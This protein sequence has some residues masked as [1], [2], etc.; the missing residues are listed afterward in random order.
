ML[1]E[2]TVPE[3]KVTNPK[4]VIGGKKLMWSVIPWR[5]L[6]GTALA[7]L[8][9]SLKYGRHNYRDAGVRASVYFDACQRHLLPWW[10]GE[11]LDP[12][13]QL[14][15]IDKAI[16]TLLVLRDGMLHG[17]WQDDRPPRVEQGW[18]AA[19]NDKAAEMIASVGEP[20]SAFTARPRKRLSRELEGL[21]T[22]AKGG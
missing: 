21:D 10:E 13:S 17:N 22:G 1:E 11:D 3:T 19:G 2:G 6:R 9:G 16:A 14:S 4:D 12:D 15:H 5:A 7:M 8:E 18:I 20:K